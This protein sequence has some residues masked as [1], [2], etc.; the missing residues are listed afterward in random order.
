[1]LAL[2]LVRRVWSRRS[3]RA[4]Q[5]TFRF[6]RICG[7][8]PSGL[9][10]Q[11][12]QDVLGIDLVVPVALDDLGGTL[13]GLLGSFGKAVKSHHRRIFLSIFLVAVIITKSGSD[14]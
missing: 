7:I 5:L 11:R 13:G 14:V 4:S 3:A 6:S 12:Q 8:T 10:D 1:M 9:L 2:G